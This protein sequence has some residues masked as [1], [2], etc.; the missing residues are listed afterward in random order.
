MRVFPLRTRGGYTDLGGFHYTLTPKAVSLTDRADGTVWWVTYNLSVSYPDGLGLISITD[1][2]APKA[3]DT[4]TYLAYDEPYFIGTAG[5]SRL[6]VRGGYLGADET[7]P[8]FSTSDQSNMHLY[9]LV[10]GFNAPMKQLILGST[11]DTKGRLYGWSPY[12]FIRTPS[13]Q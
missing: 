6:I 10:P 7:I 4:Q 11:T 2:P 13:P 8:A 9:A 3:L 12:T 1:T 5:L